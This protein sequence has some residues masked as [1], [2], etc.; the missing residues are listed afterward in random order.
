MAA[1]RSYPSRVGKSTPLAGG[2]GVESLDIRRIIRPAATGSRVI[3]MFVCCRRISWVQPLLTLQRRGSP[4]LDPLSEGEISPNR[5]F[6]HRIPEPARR[7]SADFQSAVSPISNRQDRA[8][9]HAPGSPQAPQ[10]GSPAIQQIGNL[11]Y[12]VH[13]EGVSRL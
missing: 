13:A 3:V 2:A 5:N 10:A 9:L 11:R 7:C 1:Q 4:H 8:F 6:A 12:V